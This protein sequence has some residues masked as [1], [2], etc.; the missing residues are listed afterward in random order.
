MRY[1]FRDVARNYGVLD[2]NVHNLAFSFRLG[3]TF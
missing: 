1:G 2:V 3:Y